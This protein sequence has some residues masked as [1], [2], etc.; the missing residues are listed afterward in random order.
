MK[1]SSDVQLLY[2]ASRDGFTGTAF[3]EKCDNRANTITNIKNN[4][5][6]VFGGFASSA[7]NSSGDLI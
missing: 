6:Y 4:L 7:W 3:H 5:N 2:R 1:K